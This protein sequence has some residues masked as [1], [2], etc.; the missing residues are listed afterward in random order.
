MSIKNPSSYTSS[1][2]FGDTINFNEIGFYYIK[3]QLFEDKALTDESVFYSGLNL[4]CDELFLGKFKMGS[5]YKIV[6]DEK[7]LI[8]FSVSD[9]LTDV[10]EYTLSLSNSNAEIETYYEEDGVLYVCVVGK[11]NGKVSLEISAE[12]KSKHNS[13]VQTFSSTA[14]INVNYTKD[15]VDIFMIIIWIT[16]GVFCLVIIIYLS[17]SVVKARKNDVK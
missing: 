3:I 16:F 5:E 15:E 13:K 12:A 17:I 10:G 1:L 7:I 2:D 6:D 11:G 8:S 9:A 4:H 14:T